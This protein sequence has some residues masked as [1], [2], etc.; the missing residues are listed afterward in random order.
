MDGRATID[1]GMLPDGGAARED[2]PP[3]GALAAEALAADALPGGPA[4]AAAEPAAEPVGPGARD[5]AGP[6]RGA[7]GRWLVWAFRA[8][9]WA[10]LLIVGYRGVAAIVAGTGQAGTGRAGP[11]AA[12]AAGPSGRFPTSLAEAY[13][14]QFGEVYL[15]LSPVTA[16]QRARELA[17][18]LPA[19]AQPQFGWNGTGS[20]RLQSEQVASITVRNAHYA[21]V[22][23]LAL[24][25]GRLM[26]LGVPVYAAHGGLG[27]PAE[28]AWLPAPARVSPVSAQSP[29]GTATDPAAQAALESQLPAFFRAYASDDTVTL[30]RFLA[31]GAAVTGLGGSVTFGSISAIE[32]PPGG[33]TRRIVVSVVWSMA[34]SAARSVSRTSPVS[35]APVALEMSYQMTVVR[36]AGSWYVKAI[37]SSAAQ[38]QAP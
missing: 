20:L 38:P 15:N 12:P 22:T 27:I 8:V 21:T 34:S 36:Q 16:V 5:R 23:L 17:A 9:V 14:L 19:G 30:R 29:V 18:F 11:A 33:A 13:A 1:P 25:N 4:S 26:E 28:P 31:P 6:W 24:V 37:G 2:A 32:V 7:G 3:T 35:A 10:V